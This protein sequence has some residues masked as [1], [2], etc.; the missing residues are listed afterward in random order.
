[1]G[2]SNNVVWLETHL[3]L[4]LFR[5]Q[6]FFYDAV[7]C[8]LIYL[9]MYDN[10]KNYWNAKLIALGFLSVPKTKE[11]RLRNIK[12]ACLSNQTKYGHYH[13]MVR[14]PCLTCIHFHIC[15]ARLQTHVH[16]ILEYCALICMPNNTLLKYKNQLKIN[17]TSEVGSIYSLW[18]IYKIKK[19]WHSNWMATFGKS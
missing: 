12:V 8:L 11:N 1:M 2:C 16:Q 7:L 10:S 6:I 13:T 4:S 14:V 17:F 19:G 18:I 15:V 9:E 3:S 5:F